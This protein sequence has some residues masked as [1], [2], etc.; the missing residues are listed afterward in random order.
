MANETGGGIGRII[1]IIIAA[2]IAGFLISQL[3]KRYRRTRATSTSTNG[4]TTIVSTST[5]TGTGI[6]PN[7]SNR[8][9][10]YSGVPISARAATCESECISLG[11]T[12]GAMVGGVC[13]CS[14]CGE[15][16]RK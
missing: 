8:R 3:V 6:D 14:G 4:T 9:Q 15:T 16:N 10:P 12:G 11:C 7:Q 5:N 1:L 2:L 13:K